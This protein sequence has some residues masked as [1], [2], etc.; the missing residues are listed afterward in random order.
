MTRPARSW[1]A[2][3]EITTMSPTR[4]K[5]QPAT[6]GDKRKRDDRREK[7]D[8]RRS[9]QKFAGKEQRHAEDRRAW[10]GRRQ[11]AEWRPST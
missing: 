9:R 6:A 10:V 5:E 8:R 11:A 3:K 2:T 7:S 1:P 4:T